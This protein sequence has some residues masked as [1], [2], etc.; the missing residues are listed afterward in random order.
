MPQAQL[1]RFL[2][3]AAL[4]YPIEADERT[5]ARRYQGVAE[6]LETIQP[7]TDGPSLIALRDDVRR[8]RVSEDVEA[9]LV[10]IVRATRE[11]ADLELGG[12]PRATVA[13][14]RASQAAAVLAGR[15]FVLPDDVKGL[16]RPVL[17]HRLVVDLDRSLRGVSTTSVLDGILERVPVPPL[18]AD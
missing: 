12:S 4:G 10:S 8:V 5:I 17:A 3:R 2:L 18:P 14:Y 13:L 16:V 6:P 1:D 7:V 11:H 15:S 9:Y